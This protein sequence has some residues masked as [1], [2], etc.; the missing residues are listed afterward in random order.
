MSRVRNGDTK[1]EMQVRR[2]VHGM[3]YRYRLHAKHLPG[4]RDLVFPNPVGFVI[5]I[6]LNCNRGFSKCAPSDWPTIS[7]VGKPWRADELD[8]IIADYFVMLAADLAGQPYVKSRHSKALLEKIRRTHRSVEFKH[9]NIS[10][11]LDELGL[12]WIPGYIP[13]RN[14]QNAIFDALDRYLTQHPSVL[15]AVPIRQ[16]M[17]SASDVFVEPPKPTQPKPA[18]ERLRRLVRKFDPV[19]RDHRNRSLGKAGE[20]FVFELERHRL[21]IGGSAELASR[22]RWVAAEDGDGAGFDIFSTTCQG[23]SA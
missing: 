16:S 12:P 18:S 15:E 8:E 5:A 21:T 7:K 19:E 14:Y 22:V 23:E 4:C 6:W 13:K 10:A 11:V 20:E 3:G 2:L 9:Q 17:M 1:P